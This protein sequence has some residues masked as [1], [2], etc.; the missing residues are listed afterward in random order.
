MS[1]GM[2]LVVEAG[3]NYRSNPSI[4]GGVLIC[5][6]R[7]CVVC[8]DVTEDTRKHRHVITGNGGAD[9]YELVKTDLFQF[10]ST[11]Q[12]LCLCRK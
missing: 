5:T 11:E 1:S 8:R 10:G 3:D 9:L 4:T 6:V 2:V 7:V 12:R